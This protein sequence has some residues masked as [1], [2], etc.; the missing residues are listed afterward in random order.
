MVV[1][2]CSASRHV[3]PR[4]SFIADPATHTVACPFRR[5]TSFLSIRWRY[6]TA[7]RPRC[8]TSL[9]P[10]HAHFSNTVHAQCARR[11]NT[12]PSS[13]LYFARAAKKRAQRDSAARRADSRD[14]DYLRDEVASRIVD[15]LVITVRTRPVRAYSRLGHAV[16]PSCMHVCDTLIHICR[17]HSPSHHPDSAT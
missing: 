12:Y 11:H 13:R 17:M 15:R 6:L 4:T 3:V 14:F 5:A 2:F 16:S 9:V 1:V 8:D 7:L 10:S